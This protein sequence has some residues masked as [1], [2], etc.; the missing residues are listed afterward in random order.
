VRP[1]TSGVSPVSAS[2]ALSAVGDIWSHL[3]LWPVAA[4]GLFADLWSKHWAFTH[5]PSEPGAA[6]ELIPRLLSFRR[7]L[8][9]GALFG[10]GKGLW[11][12]FIVASILALGFVWYLFSQS[13]RNRR[14]LHVALGLILAGAMGNLYDRAW[15]MADVVRTSHGS[16][17]GIVL[18]QTDDII[19]L[20]TYPDGRPLQ[21]FNKKRDD[22]TVKRQGVV[23]DFIK[24]EPKFGIEL[25]PWVFNVADVL[26]VAGVALLLLNFWW[27]RRE[28]RSHAAAASGEGPPVASSS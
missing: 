22:V 25:W 12:V 23:R 11:L 9:D 28:A 20:G 13:T 21:R 10:L 8:N 4:L 16:F 6:R 27:E 7:T 19:D 2:S 18:R 24:V 17:T 14:S 26:L 5:L 1:E 15:V 3:R